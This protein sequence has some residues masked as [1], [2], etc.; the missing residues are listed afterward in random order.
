MKIL[1]LEYITAGGLNDVPL[2]ASLLQEGILMRDALLKDFSELEEVEVITTCD[3]RISLPALALQ[4][5]WIDEK[6]NPMKIWQELLQ[7]CEAALVIAPESDGILSGLTEVIEASKVKNLGCNQ[8]AVDIASN[9]YA[10]YQT[11]KNTNIL[12]IP[13]YRANELMESF[14]PD[15]SF[16]HGYVVKPNDGAGCSETF[17]FSDFAVLLDWLNLNP[18]KQANNIIQPFQT[19]IPASIS[20]LCREGKAWV[21]SCNQQM[22]AIETTTNQASIQYQGSLVNGLT[23][24]QASFEKLANNIARA[25]PG[26]NGYVGI[27][28]IVD[29]ETIYIV[30]IN[31]RITTS[32]IGLR[33]SLNCNSAQL[34]LDLLGHRSFILPQDLANKPVEISVNELSE[35]TLSHHG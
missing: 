4:V 3:S 27:D 33:E 31:P 30:E 25:L 10:V 8:H 19:G 7:T 29:G 34:I 16:K 18:E 17:Y 13:T 24:Y 22:I 23:N 2:P 12:T 6:S 14:V 15:E 26:L 9:K 20:V 35:H 32:Y 28:V 5:V 21:L 11:L 1:L